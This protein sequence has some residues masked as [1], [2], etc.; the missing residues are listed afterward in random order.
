MI[1]AKRDYNNQVVEK[2]YNKNY[3]NPEYMYQT[4][5][6]EI[7][8]LYNSKD[9]SQHLTFTDVLDSFYNNVPGVIRS[10]CALSF[11]ILCSSAP[12]CMRSSLSGLSTTPTKRDL[13]H[14]N[15]EENMLYE[16]TL[17]VRSGIDKFIQLHRLQVVRS[18]LPCQRHHHLKRAE[19]RWI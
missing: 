6:P 17:Q 1:E 14:L 9:N 10:G 16:D 19:T 11:T 13:F 12:S 2:F 5:G 3:Y 15:S 8:R 18:S 4:E 7:M